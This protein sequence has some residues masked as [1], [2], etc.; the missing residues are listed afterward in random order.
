M[1]ADLV[2]ICKKNIMLS[3]WFYK[4]SKWKNQ[5]EEENVFYLTKDI[6]YNILLHYKMAWMGSSTHPLGAQRAAG[7][8][9]ADFNG[10]EVVPE[11]R[12]RNQ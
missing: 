1:I 8:W 7:R 2:I 4:K 11:L 9:K 5:G 3:C 10:V 12:F 6:P